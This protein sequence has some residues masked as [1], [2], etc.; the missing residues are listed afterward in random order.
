MAPL[1]YIEVLDGKGGVAE[2]IA[3]DAFPITIGRSYS[4]RVILDDPYVCPMHVEIVQDSQGDLSARD[5]NSVNGLHVAKSDQR[6]ACLTLSSGTQFRIGHSH[7]RYCSVDH[8][9]APTLVDGAVTRSRWLQSLGASFAGAAVFLLLCLDSYLG[10]VERVT[11]A[12]VVSEPLAT[13][14]ML[15]VWA[16]LWSL[17]GRIVVARVNF[18]QH[19]VI[20]CGAIAGFLALTF[21]SEWLEFLFPIVPALW[22]VGLAGTGVILAA[23]VYGHLG[24]ASN[25][26]RSSRLWAALAVSVA[27]LSVSA[28]SDMASRSKFSNVME[29]SG[30][31]KPI[32]AVWLPTVS[33]ERFMGD[34]QKLKRELDALAQKAKPEP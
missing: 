12:Q 20:A 29:F 7:L 14:A 11:I 23:L 25:L 31:L 32:N 9:L 1:G 34:T 22:L 3:I 15:L 27:A 8:P 2:R 4:N 19:V 18:S 30:V 28:I 17:A 33:V 24:F 6:V 10:S 21:L 26:R 5:L 16:G 13:F